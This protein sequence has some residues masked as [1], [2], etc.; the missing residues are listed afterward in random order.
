MCKKIR[1]NLLCVASTMSDASKSNIC[2]QIYVHTLFISE[3][4]LQDCNIT[5]KITINC[6]KHMAA[7]INF[8]L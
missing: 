5:K 2:H 8:P 1:F 7:V 4:A 6:H 3:M